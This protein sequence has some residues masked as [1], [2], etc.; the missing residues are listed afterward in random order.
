M[1]WGQ[2]T[3][4]EMTIN[5]NRNPVLSQLIAVSETLKYSAAVAETGANVNHYKDISKQISI[6]ILSTY[7][8]PRSR[9]E[10]PI[11][12]ETRWMERM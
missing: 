1:E 10:S 11:P 4:G 3:Y 8:S 2:E 9:K 6:P 7:I 5:A 12:A